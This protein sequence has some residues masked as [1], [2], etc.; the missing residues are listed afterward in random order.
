MHDFIAGQLL[1]E[2]IA[3]DA[4]N[5]DLLA[6]GLDDFKRRLQIAAEN[7]TIAL[8]KMLG[9][10]SGLVAA[11]VRRPSDVDHRRR[12]Y[13]SIAHRRSRFGSAL[14][15]DFRLPAE[16]LALAADVERHDVPAAL[17]AQLLQQRLPPAPGRPFDSPDPCSRRAR[18]SPVAAR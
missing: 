15:L 1:F 13:R 8:T 5:A 17:V 16:T 7:A 11:A 10:S 9:L 18:C 3:E 12:A 4:R 14:E 6:A 2:G